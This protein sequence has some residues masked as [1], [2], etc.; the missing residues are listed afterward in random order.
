MKRVRQDLIDR[1]LRVVVRGLGAPLR[2]CADPPGPADIIAVLGAPLGRDGTLSDVVEER[3]A[4]G[5]ALWKQGLAPIIVMSGGRGPN[6]RA[7][8]SEA[9]VMVERAEALG[10]PPRALVTEDRSQNTSENASNVKELGAM[11]GWRSVLV[12]SQP[13]HLR[14]ALLW[15]ERCGFA[16]QGVSSAH[17]LELREPRRGLRWIMR[18]YGSLTRDL[19]VTRRPGRR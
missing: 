10:V 1:A 13:F 17:S 7:G 5:V 11:A 8:R 3:V 19:L 6:V 4:T 2:R 14:R 15:F 12:V 9:E 18:E 16:A